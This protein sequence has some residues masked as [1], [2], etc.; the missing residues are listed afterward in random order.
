MAYYMAVTLIILLSYYANIYFCPQAFFIFCD[1]IIYRNSF[2]MWLGGFS[3]I[4]MCSFPQSDSLVRQRHLLSLDLF[5]ES[6]RQQIQLLMQSEKPEPA[7]LSEAKAN[8]KSWSLELFYFALLT[9]YFK[10]LLFPC[11]FLS[12]VEGLHVWKAACLV[13]N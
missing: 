1:Q 2:I 6:S 7:L 13:T 11:V 3:K 10:M 9:C 5:L 4:I 12:P 8:D